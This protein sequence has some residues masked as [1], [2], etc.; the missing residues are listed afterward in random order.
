M[1]KIESQTD[2]M[3]NYLVI[4]VVLTHGLIMAEY[5]TDFSKRV[6][7]IQA[8]QLINSRFF[9]YIMSFGFLFMVASAIVIWIISSFLFHLMAILFD[10]QS[11][12]KAFKKYS[13]LLY[14]FPALG[15]AVACV[16]SDRIQ[17]PTKNTAE[18]LKSDTT[19][20]TINW[21]INISSIVYYVLL[22]PIIKYLYRINWLKS[23]GAILLPI[24]SIYL[25]GQLFAN[26]VF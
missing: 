10:G 7:E 23:I 19:F 15:F 2:K 24:A 9:I 5:I 22:I 13:G 25:F 17:L 21:I 8:G 11:T 16:L 1:I 4:T 12:F 6:L 26:Y 3:S 18:F 20:Q 14:I